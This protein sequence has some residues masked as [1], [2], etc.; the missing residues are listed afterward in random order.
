MANFSKEVGK[1]LLVACWHTPLCGILAHASFWHLTLCL[2]NVQVPITQTVPRMVEYAKPTSLSAAPMPAP[3]T[4][5]V[6]P[7]YPYGTTPYGTTPYGTTMPMSMPYAPY[8][9]YPLFTY[10]S[11]KPQLALMLWSCG[12]LA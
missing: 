3:M 2:L 6:L 10:P 8:G 9:S 7:G 1:R 12:S 11:S 5:G 4:T